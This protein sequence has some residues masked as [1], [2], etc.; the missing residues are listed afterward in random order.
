MGKKYKV[1]IKVEGRKRHACAGC[2][3]QFSYML[4]RDVTGE[5]RTPE[6][7]AAQ[8]QR[9][10]DAEL[11][12]GVDVHA[13][14]TCGLVQPEMIAGLR[15]SRFIWGMVIAA[16][17]IGAAM[18]LIPTH[19]TSIAGA[20]YVA[21]GAAALGWLVCLSGA[22]TNPNRYLE[23]NRYASQEKVR[24]GEL[25]VDQSPSTSPGL[26]ID[27]HGGLKASHVFG[28]ALAAAAMVAAAL[29]ILAS[30]SLGWTEN[31]TCYPSVIG[32]GDTSRF[33]FG[34]QITAVNSYWSG[35]AIAKATN[36]DEL[37]IGSLRLDVATKQSNWGD[38][39]SG[40]HVGNRTGAMWADVT[41]PSDE[42][43]AG[44][45]LKLE[46]DVTATYPKAQGSEFNNELGQFHQ[47]TAVTLSPPG[48]GLLY[49]RLAWMGET[50]S[51]LLTLTAGVI[52]LMG[53][54]ALA[55]RARPCPCPQPQVSAPAPQLVA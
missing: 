22:L 53:C 26:R 31:D 18:I 2:G 1:S 49:W 54:S 52:L 30:K 33:Y 6:K 36:L 8:A 11:A 35:S 20:A 9:L 32:P 38:T 55:A 19:V 50:A 23:A 37:G 16:V 25:A 45:E 47:A 29:P 10:G 3:G 41:I 43:L 17:G 14:P 34:Q 48:A 46:L 51:L 15:R 13:C 40:K 42:R 28:L 5:S 12:T 4:R 21:L 39:I 24:S 7:A 27:E 44:K